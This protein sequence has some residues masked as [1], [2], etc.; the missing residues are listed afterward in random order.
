MEEKG[1]GQRKSGAPEPDNIPLKDEKAP[2]SLSLASQLF[3]DLS[4]I[5]LILP[6]VL[7]IS[8]HHFSLS[9]ISW[10]FWGMSEMKGGRGGCVYM[11]DGVARHAEW[12]QDEG[13]LPRRHGWFLGGAVWPG[14]STAPVLDDWGREE[15]RWTSALPTRIAT[16]TY[17]PRPT[18]PA[19]P[20][21]Q[22]DNL[23][24]PN[25]LY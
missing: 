11:E 13:K 10:S 17:P 8:S 6:A 1:A 14:G 19:F 2:R 7:L 23:D 21:L 5:F 25:F 3:L 24:V 12:P 22:C 9:F 18:L 15:K 20:H 4:H 16:F